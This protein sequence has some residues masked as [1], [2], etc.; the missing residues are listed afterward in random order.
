MNRKR[1]WGEE[2]K[3][4]LDTI[5]EYLRFNK[6]NKYIPQNC[7]LLDLG[8][9]YNGTLLKKYRNSIKKGVGIDLS[10]NDKDTDIKLIEGR[11]DKKIKLRSNEFDIITSLAV[12]EHVESP[13]TMLKEAYRLLKKDGI[14]LITTP[15]KYNKPILEFLAFRI[16]VISKDEIKDHKRY[17]DKFSLEKELALAGF[18]KNK[19]KV[20]YFQ[21]GL[22]IFAIAKK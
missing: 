18:S 22:N 9:G 16:N 6:I 20:E 1:S 13:K 14:L 10:V 5:I 19:I 7:V 2:N 8:C 11:I 12:I 3:S 21:L 4:T 17:Y 15:S